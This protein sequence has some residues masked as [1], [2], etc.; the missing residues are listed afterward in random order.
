VVAH[1]ARTTG[2]MAARAELAATAAGEAFG[3]KS[4]SASTTN[5]DKC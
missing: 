4:K 2:T 1:T 3:H 5:E